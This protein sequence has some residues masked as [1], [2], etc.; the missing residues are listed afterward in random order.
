MIEIIGFNLRGAPWA[1]WRGTEGRG[2]AWQ[3]CGVVRQCMERANES[4]ADSILR[5][6]SGDRI[7]DV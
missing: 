1:L 5:K 3:W 2:D 7:C 4:L 6:Q